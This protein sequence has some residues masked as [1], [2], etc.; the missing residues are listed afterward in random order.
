MARRSEEEIL[1]SIVRMG[2]ILSVYRAWMHEE[3]GSPLDPKEPMPREQWLAELK[4]AGIR[5]SKVE[6]GYVEAINDTA[7]DLQEAMQYSP[8][9][10]ESFLSFYRNEKGREFWDDVGK[11][12]KAAKA[13]VRRGS[14]RDTTE[15]RLLNSILSN[16]DQ[17]VFKGTALTRAEALLAEFEATYESDGD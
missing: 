17:T 3:Y 1:E 16:V 10:A 8:A 7:Q 12:D 9:E 2:A 6:R 11:P 5:I 14:I 15:W 13:I 4:K